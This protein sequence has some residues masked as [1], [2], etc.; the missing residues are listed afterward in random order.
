MNKHTQ[1]LRVIAENRRAR[2][3]Y[4][5]SNKLEAGIVLHGWEMRSL[6]AGRA[7]IQHAYI[8]PK[9]GEC[10]LLGARIDPIDSTVA[11]SNP[12]P[13]RT[14]KLLLHHREIARLLATTSRRGLSCLPLRLYWKGPLVK[15][16]I[17]IGRGRSKYDKRQH[18][19][20]REWR[21]SKCDI[22]KG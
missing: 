9:A 19:R 15:C 13:E 12:D 22:M 11:Y 1:K 2:Y 7:N 21:R 16:E 3:D 20:D 14:R 17:A 8:L 10:W 6:R 4:Q 5:L 18:L